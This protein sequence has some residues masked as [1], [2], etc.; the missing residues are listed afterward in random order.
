MRTIDEINEEIEEIRE[1][2]FELD[3]VYLHGDEHKVI[4]LLRQA[5]RC[6][7]HICCMSDISSDDRK[8]LKD[9]LDNI[10]KTKLLRLNNNFS[11]ETL[12]NMLVGYKRGYIK[13]PMDIFVIDD[14][15]FTKEATFDDFGQVFE[16]ET[17]M[18][19]NMKPYF[20][21][22]SLYFTYDEDDYLFTPKFDLT[23][24]EIM[25]ISKFLSDNINSI[26]K[27][28]ITKPLYETN[29]EKSFSG[30][31]G[32]TYGEARGEVYINKR[33]NELAQNIIDKQESDIKFCVLNGDDIT[34][35][36]VH[37]SFKDNEPVWTLEKTNNEVWRL[38]EELL[39]NKK[40][41]KQLIK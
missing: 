11:E 29:T 22:T 31:R 37:Q 20:N 9:K 8:Q 27:E 25:T 13:Y 16:I 38:S 10:M 30:Y 18:F 32:L 36:Y 3:K 40:D 23:R 5:L 17:F 15:V 24:E 19:D 41:N 35:Y 2:E 34:L 26:C 21:I 14:A 12:N 4:T 28:N 7:G 39:K 6:Y 1:S 33:F